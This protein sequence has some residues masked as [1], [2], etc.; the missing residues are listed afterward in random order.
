MFHLEDTALKKKK[1]AWSLYE[2]QSVVAEIKCYK[3]YRGEL[4]LV[5]N[6]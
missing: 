3:L 4:N 1:E 2:T 6:L 5:D